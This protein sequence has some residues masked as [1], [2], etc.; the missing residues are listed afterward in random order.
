MARRT[1]G[2]TRSRTPASSVPPPLGTEQ[3]TTHRMPL[4]E[5]PEAY[6]M[7]QHTRDGAIKIVLEP[8]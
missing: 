8:S 3:L 7:F 1:C 6:A 4:D 5:A 2:S